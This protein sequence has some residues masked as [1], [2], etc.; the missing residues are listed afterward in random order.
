MSSAPLQRLSVVD[1]LA[2]QLRAQILDGSIAPGTALREQELSDHYEVSRHTLRAALR[3]LASEGLVRIEPNRGAH[4]PML[5]DVA[6]AELFELR[7]ALELE[8]A[9]LAL[10]RNGGRLPRSVHDALAALAA[11][12]EARS[13]RWR[14]VAR[15]H[16]GFHN[17]LVEASTSPRIERAYTQLA[18]ELR[19]FLIQLRPTWPITRMVPHHVQLVAR[20]EQGDLGALRTHLADGFEAVLSRTTG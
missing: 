2:A 17:A 8:A 9:H 7:A 10:E 18:G 5:D 15:A 3:A 6:L 20:L 11:R 14:D 19:L 4:V 1:E 12:C 13:P 16:E